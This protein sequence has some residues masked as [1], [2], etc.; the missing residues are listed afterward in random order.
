MENMSKLID[1]QN[2]LVD[3]KFVLFK[4]D[5]RLLREGMLK[6]L[7]EESDKSALHNAAHTVEAGLCTVCTPLTCRPTCSVL[8]PVQL[9]RLFLLLSSC[10]SV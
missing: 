3:N 2:R 10:R 8:C 7:K 9:R 6:R 1:I 5:R 4:P